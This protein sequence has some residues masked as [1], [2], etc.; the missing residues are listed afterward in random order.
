MG[1][2]CALFYTNLFMT[3]FELKQIYPYVQEMS[4]LRYVYDMDIHNRTK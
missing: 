2:M 1:T 4:L 3:N